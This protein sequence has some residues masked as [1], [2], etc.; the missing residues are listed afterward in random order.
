[1]SRSNS[2]KTLHRLI[3]LG[4][5][6]R[7]VLGA[8]L[9][10][11]APTV[12]RV[13]QPLLER[14]MIRP[15]ER[16]GAEPLSGKPAYQVGIVESYTTF[17]GL[18][19]TDSSIYGAVV[20]MGGS[21]LAHDERA[22][23]DTTVPAVVDTVV[24]LVSALSAD[25]TISGVGI[26]IGG[27]VNSGKVISS[28]FLSWTNV[29]LENILER[30]LDVTVT[31]ANDVQAFAQAESW[32]G[33]A[34]GQRSFV[35]ISVGSGIGCCTVM[36]GNVFEGEHG[37]AGMIGHLRVGDGGPTCEM[38]HVGCAR[39]YASSTCILRYLEKQYGISESY[40]N[41]VTR[42]TAGFSPERAIG[43]AA[44][45][46]VAQLVSGAIGFLDPNTVVVSGDGISMVMAFESEFRKAIS[47]YR[48]WAGEKV[49]VLLQ[50]MEFSAWARGGAAVAMERWTQE[51][52]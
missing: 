20:D 32:W 28:G 25:F 29:E 23:S 26:G 33:F 45:E 24:E 41:F 2:S 37:S 18:K 1:M 43:V 52:L 50:K 4:P 38:G 17:V 8:E 15:L 39:A 30:R 48:H 19:I 27:R 12:T 22:L 40:D 31:V 42:A 47:T 7:G 5:A 35:L 21:V 51:A 34:G 44:V 11:S 9:E 49:D 14:G 10:I 16:I 36:D 13:L 3:A 46:A 6:T